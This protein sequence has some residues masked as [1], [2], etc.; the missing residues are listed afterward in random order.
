LGLEFIY[1]WPC[2][3]AAMIEHSRNSILNSLTKSLALGLQINERNM[4]I[5]C[6]S[7][8]QDVG[9]RHVG[10]ERGHVIG[11]IPGHI[12]AYL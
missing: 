3:E 10:P 8:G 11:S 5:V 12:K 6:W 7:R 9:S 4:L 2:D 1:F